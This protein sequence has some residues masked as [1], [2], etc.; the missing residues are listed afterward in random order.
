MNKIPHVQ[1][2]SDNVPCDGC[3]I[4]CHNDA[5][6]ITPEDYKRHRFMFWRKYIP[7]DVVSHPYYKGK[8][9]LAHKPNGHC[10]YLDDADKGEGG[11][12]I[13]ECKPTMCKKMD[14]RAIAQRISYTQARKM[15]GFPIEVFKKGKELLKLSVANR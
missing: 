7:Y 2:D 1:I 12:S 11:C 9:M 13:H 15:K 14:C 3:T 6:L 8:F 10:I 4:C 5:V